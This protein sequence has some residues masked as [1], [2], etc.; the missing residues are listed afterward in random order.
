M[1]LEVDEAR[2]LETLEDSFSSRQFRGRV[3]GEERC[4]IDELSRVRS[5]CRE[6][7]VNCAQY[8]NDQVVLRDCLL[9]VRACHWSDAGCRVQCLGNKGSSVRSTNIRKSYL[10]MDAICIWMKNLADS[11]KLSV[12]ADQSLRKA[13]ISVVAR[14]CRCRVRDEGHTPQTEGTNEFLPIT[15][16]GVAPTDLNTTITT[17]ISVIYYI[18]CHHVS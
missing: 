2:A 14:P 6:H 9:Y 13:A 8:R 18:V 1:V 15:K 17:T 7:R 12:S 5:Y 3:V 16:S 10:G 4:K 11:R